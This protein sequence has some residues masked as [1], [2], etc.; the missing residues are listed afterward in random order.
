MSNLISKTK[1]AVNSNV[2]TF[3]KKKT[4]RCYYLYFSPYT[5]IKILTCQI[6]LTSNFK[7]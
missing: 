1:Q 6:F 7:L 2:I 5:N 3:Q 4:C